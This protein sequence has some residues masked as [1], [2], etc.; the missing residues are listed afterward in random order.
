MSDAEKTPAEPT[1]PPTGL[2]I[3]FLAAAL[4]LA[5]VLSFVALV[6]YMAFSPPRTVNPPPVPSTKPAHE[7]RLLLGE[8]PRDRR[9]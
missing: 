9:T 4:A 5:L 3:L 6:A 8:A 7:G 1:P 2:G